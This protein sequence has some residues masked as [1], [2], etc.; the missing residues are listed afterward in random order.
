MDGREANWK[1]ANGI[2]Y[3]PPDVA[4]ALAGWAVRSEKDGVFDPCFG[5]CAFL[6]AALEVLMAQDGFPTLLREA[7]A[8]ATRRSKE[9][10]G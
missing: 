9:L 7:V 8:A 3:T 5:G 2:F 1:R 10:G 4:R 6:E